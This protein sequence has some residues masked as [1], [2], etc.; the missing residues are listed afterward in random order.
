[1]VPSEAADP[2]HFMSQQQLW[3]KQILSTTLTYTPHSFE[4]VG[5]V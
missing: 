3:T 5:V 1:M 2:G 4:I